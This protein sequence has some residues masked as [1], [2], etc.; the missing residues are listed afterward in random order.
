VQVGVYRRGLRRWPD[1]ESAP[2]AEEEAEAGERRRFD[3]RAVAVAAVVAFGLLL[4]GT[5]WPL[6]GAVAAW[7]AVAWAAAQPDRAALPTGLALAG[8]LAGSA[9]LFGLVGGAG[10]AIALRR[11]L[12]AGLLVLAATWLRAAAGSAGL[13]EV[14]RRGLGRV[15]AVPSMREAVRTLDELGS[16]RRLLAAGRDLAERLGRVPKRP[17]PLLDAVLDWVAH[18]SARLRPAKRPPRPRLALGPLDGLLVTLAG[19]PVLALA[20]G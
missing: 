9:L 15:R 10:V 11:A 17:L 4:S 8:L 20:L 12:R 7:L 18:E 6:L 16:D 19:L 14:F 5:E 1:L 2:E 3:P 13:R